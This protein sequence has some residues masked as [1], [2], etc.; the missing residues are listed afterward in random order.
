VKVLVLSGT[1]LNFWFVRC[2]GAA[3]L[4]I[5]G[6]SGPFISMDWLGYGGSCLRSF[7][8]HNVRVHAEYRAVL[9][10]DDRL[11]DVS[12]ET[13]VEAVP[14]PDQNPGIAPSVYMNTN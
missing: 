2:E 7:G 14:A 12:R 1:R 4:V 3:L 10:P 6:S 5:F 13:V 8:M 11:L 9:V